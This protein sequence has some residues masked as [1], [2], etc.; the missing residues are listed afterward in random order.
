M[1]T[2]GRAFRIHI[3]GESHG[4]GLGVCVDGCPA[5]VRLDADD[6]LPDLARRRSGARGTTPR[7]ESDTPKI[8]SGV[9]RNCTTGSPI[10]ILFA[11][12]NVRSGDYSE[13]AATPRP[14]HADFTGGRKYK[15]FNDPAGGGHFS[16]RVTLG[17]VAAGVIAKRVIAPVSVEAWL[18]EAGGSTDVDAAVDAAIAAH[19]SVGGIVEG[20]VAGCPVGWGEPFFDGVESLAAHILFSIPAVKG[21]EFG[22][23][24][25]AARM[26]G[27]EHNDAFATAVGETSTNN[28]GGIN[29][30]IS[31]GNEITFRLAV[32]PTSSIGRAQQTLNFDSGRIEE[33]RVKGRHDSCIALRVPVIA[34]AAMAV[35]L[36]DLKMLSFGGI[37]IWGSE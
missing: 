18:A 20:R 34:E 13:F 19:D 3:F 12:E 35:T 31:N 28:A 24:F 36:A 8:V 17:L 5:G 37:G 21:V 10:T 22:A 27:S 26:R 29:G 6:F 7:T 14:G 32:K 9:Y 23:G 1:N 15:G 30:G 2:F 4:A 16:G 25:A 33:L 11:N